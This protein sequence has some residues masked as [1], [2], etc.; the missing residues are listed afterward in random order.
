MGKPLSLLQLP[1]WH[2]ARASVEWTTIGLIFGI[3]SWALWGLGC[4]LRRGLALVQY[5]ITW[6]MTLTSLVGFLGMGCKIASYMGM[7]GFTDL[8]TLAP[9]GAAPPPAIVDYPVG[10]SRDSYI[11]ACGIASIGSLIRHVMKTQA[12]T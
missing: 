2:T 4:R 9:W 7:V 10:T 8:T 1:S 6:S 12:G 3:A 5:G 11:F